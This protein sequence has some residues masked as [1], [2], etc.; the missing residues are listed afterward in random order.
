MDHEIIKDSRVDAI[1][2]KYAWIR[3][4]Y[5][6][7]EENIWVDQKNHRIY[8]P[9]LPPP[10]DPDTVMLAALGYLPSCATYKKG[11]GW[12]N[13]DT[14]K[15]LFASRANQINNVIINSII[16]SPQE[17]Q[18]VEDA[19]LKYLPAQL[20]ENVLDK[21]HQSY[22]AP[23]KIF[24]QYIPEHTNDEY[25]SAVSAL[26][27][28]EHLNSMQFGHMFE[29]DDRIAYIKNSINALRHVPLTT[30][31]NDKIAID[32]NGDLQKIEIFS[33]SDKI[34][35]KNAAANIITKINKNGQIDGDKIIALSDIVV[36][37]VITNK[38]IQ[39]TNEMK[40]QIKIIQ[41]IMLKE[42]KR[43]DIIKDNKLTKAYIAIGE[44]TSNDIRQ[45]L[46]ILQSFH[47]NKICDA[48]FFKNA[49]DGS[50]VSEING[51][52]VC[53]VYLQLGN[54]ARLETNQKR[55]EFPKDKDLSNISDAGYSGLEI[56]RNQDNPHHLPCVEYM[57]MDAS[58]LKYTA[59]ELSIIAEKHILSKNHDIEKIDKYQEKSL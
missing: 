40:E 27:I 13:N 18:K 4:S 38:N 37:E 41:D 46:S 47:P 28:Y 23:D 26:K 57:I 8:P 39:V 51:M 52:D 33:D 15:P 34:E 2:D 16:L 50:R 20:R 56:I 5:Y 31:N 55:Y 11:L 36:K 48:V 12:I 22:Y 7:N 14:L 6:K 9:E 21:V 32:Q 42:K 10:T 17:I 1:L 29:F 59:Y 43:E 30:I 54:Y 35:I 25:I 45:E 44:K 53:E 49:Q 58:L 24:Y 19:V 3:T